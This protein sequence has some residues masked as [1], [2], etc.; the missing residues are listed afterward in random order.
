MAISE[1]N[2]GTD[3]TASHSVF[4]PNNVIGDSQL[5]VK[6]T[7]TST[8]TTTATPS[9]TTIT[10]TSPTAVIDLTTDPVM[11][12]MLSILD[13]F[14]SES[15]PITSSETSPTTTS[16]D[17]DHETTTTAEVLTKVESTL[18]PQR[19]QV[20]NNLQSLRE[21]LNNLKK[22]AGVHD[23]SSTQGA[24]K[25]SGF[26]DNLENKIQIVYSNQTFDDKPVLEVSTIC[27]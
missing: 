11:N 12:V 23:F 1:L 3:E 26:K 22:S 5:D 20:Q 16:S 19:S 13:E 2:S 4:Q 25:T 7:S 14:S 10:V 18:T 6:T 21:R 27:F 24:Q 17:L 9:T 15:V 8:T